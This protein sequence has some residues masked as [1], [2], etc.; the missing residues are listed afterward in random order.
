MSQQVFEPRR[1]A[2]FV[3]WREFFDTLQQFLLVSKWPRNGR[4]RWVGNRFELI[5]YIVNTV[6]A[7]LS[8][9]GKETDIFTEKIKRH[10]QAPQVVLIFREK[11]N[12]I[13]IAEVTEIDPFQLQIVE[14]R[15][16]NLRHKT[17]GEGPLWDTMIVED[18]ALCGSPSLQPLGKLAAKV[19]IKP[20]LLKK[21]AQDTM[22]EAV[23]AGSEIEAG[24]VD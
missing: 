19:P 4:L 22:I 2:D 10:Q 1:F 15:Q 17:R 18:A 21:V 23:V 9:L 12:I 13:D 7:Y 20:E 5:F 8:A 3:A 6:D 11:P 16:N 24:S 14:M